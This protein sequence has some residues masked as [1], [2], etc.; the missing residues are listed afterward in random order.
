[1]R[2]QKIEYG[3]DENVKLLQNV[4][5]SKVH[6][7]SVQ[8]ELLELV[9]HAALEK[10]TVL[11]RVMYGCEYRLPLASS[12]F[13]RFHFLCLRLTTSL[14]EAT[15]A[16]RTGNFADCEGTCRPP[17][18]F[19]LTSNR[20]APLGLAPRRD[21]LAN[22]RRRQD[23]DYFVCHLSRRLKQAADGFLW[24]LCCRT[25]VGFFFLATRTAINT[26]QW[27]FHTEG[28]TLQ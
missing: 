10:Y 28:D 19:R 27:Q 6:F 14:R 1:M 25:V 20:R 8:S 12:Q 7:E 26:F 17:P 11:R 4:G 23:G 9:S 22:A 18:P 24:V 3:S 15:D 13:A 2:K 21:K 5:R 16:Q